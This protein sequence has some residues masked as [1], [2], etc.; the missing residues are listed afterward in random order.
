MAT[1]TMHS[2]GENQPATRKVSAE[3]PRRV[4]LTLPTALHEKMKE[5]QAETNA[6]A[7]VDVVKDALITY[8]ALVKEHKLGKEI[9]VRERESGRETTYA[10]FMRH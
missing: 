9:V 7:L 3:A 1:A 8:L 4:H 5:V 2:Y 10:L 6:N